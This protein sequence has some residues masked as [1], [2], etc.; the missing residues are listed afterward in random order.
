MA[1]PSKSFLWHILAKSVLWVLTAKHGIS[2]IK[3][4]KN[5]CSM[6]DFL[7]ILAMEAIEDAHREQERE[8]RREE[9]QRENN[10]DYNSD[11]NDDEEQDND[12]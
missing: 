4:G 2:F 8:E 9:M 12:W 7:D 11:Y 5:N 6:I 1:E 10:F 3:N